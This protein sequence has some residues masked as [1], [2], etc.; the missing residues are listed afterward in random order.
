MA[1]FSFPGRGRSARDGLVEESDAWT[2]IIIAGA[3]RELASVSAQSLTFAMGMDRPQ[4]PARF[5][6]Q[7]PPSCPKPF[8][9]IASE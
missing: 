1:L 7:R 5:I 8:I 4:R 2:P 3:R 9:L 6:R